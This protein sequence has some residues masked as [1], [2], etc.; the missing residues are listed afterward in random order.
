MSKVRILKHGERNRSLSK[1]LLKGKIYYDWVVTTAFY[2]S[3]HLLEHRL[4]PIIINSK[5][6]KNISQVRKSLNL[7]GRHMAREKIVELHTNL[8]ISIKYKWLD[9]KSR[10]A[11]YTTYKISPSEGSKA[12]E[13]LD[14]IYKYCS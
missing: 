1:D 2:S 8:D 14:F 9:D 12:E 10:Y 7:K 5:E 11:R 13:Y 6:C 4:L 3:I